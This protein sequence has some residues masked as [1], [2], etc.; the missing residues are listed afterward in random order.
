MKLKIGVYGSAKD[1][2]KNVVA[3]AREIGKLIAEND[4][5]LVTGACGGIP[6]E[7]LKSAKAHKGFTIGFSP[8][9]NIQEHKE[10]GYPEDDFDILVFTGFGKKG[11]NVVSVRTCDAAIFISGGSGSLNEFTIAYDEGK[12]CGILL[13]SGGITEILKDLEEKYLSGRKKSGKVIY[14]S[15]PEKLVK[16][17]LETLDKR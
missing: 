10:I 15:E 2:N 12:V 4:C 11:R 14:E 8:A 7:A 13:G 5:M 6:H 3:A 1:E 9:E 16:K 17:V